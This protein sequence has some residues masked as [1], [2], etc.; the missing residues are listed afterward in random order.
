VPPSARP[1]VRRRPWR[2]LVSA[3]VLA[4]AVLLVLYAG[5]PYSTLLIAAAAG[6][7]AAEGAMLAFGSQRSQ[8]ATRWRAACWAA[9]GLAYLGLACLAFLWLRAR[10][11]TGLALTVWLLAVIWAADSGA[12]LVGRSLGRDKLAPRLS[13]NKT[14][15]GFWGGLASGAVAGGLIAAIWPLAAVA[16]GAG[17]P[18]GPGP[19]VSAALAAGLAA[20]GQGGD[21]LESAYKRHFGAKDSGRIIPGHGGLLDRADALLAAAP[22]LAVA[23]WTGV[24][25]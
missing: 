13:P 8:G 20:I 18:G 7:M 14:W 22:A 4:P 15:A 24:G 11:E 9:A 1:A 21:L 17:L 25:G 16:T 10:P 23:V 19:A 12:M 6:V 2:R 5:P 3:A